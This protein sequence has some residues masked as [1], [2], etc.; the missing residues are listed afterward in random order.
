[1]GS[2]NHSRYREKGRST[3]R[4][5][6]QT[7]WRRKDRAKKKAATKKK[8]GRKSVDHLSTTATEADVDTTVSTSKPSSFAGDVVDSPAEDCIQK[9]FDEYFTNI[10]PD[11]KN[12]YEYLQFDE[13]DDPDS[14][15]K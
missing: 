13:L 9:Y 6:Y 12:I 15:F 7:E 11:E 2:L 5:A 10:L 1:M 8:A 14:V 3:N 4:R